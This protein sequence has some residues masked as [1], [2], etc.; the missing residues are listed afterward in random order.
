MESASEGADFGGG[1]DG[2][3]EGLAMLV[4][5]WNWI[6]FLLGLL[7]LSIGVSGL[8]LGEF[9]GNEFTVTLTLAVGG[10]VSITAPFAGVRV[11]DRGIRYRGILKRATVP[12]EKI[13]SI[14]VDHVGSSGGLFEA[15]MPVVKVAEG[16]DLPLL[17]LAGYTSGQPRVNER[18][19]R[20]VAVMR[21]EFARA[22]R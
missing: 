18:V 6:S 15:E 19:R 11:D 13:R 16:K 1:H 20:Q 21:E 12:W 5:T 9:S 2:F 14:S 3:S 7:V 22:G 8:A 17:V 10:W 4:G